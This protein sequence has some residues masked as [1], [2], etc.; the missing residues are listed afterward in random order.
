MKTDKD[1]L[2]FFIGTGLLIVA[3]LEVTILPYVLNMNFPTLF[4]P[5]DKHKTAVGY[6]YMLAFMSYFFSLGYFK[7][8][9][10]AI[11]IILIYYILFQYFVSL[12]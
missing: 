10:A 9:M 11:S 6:I 2:L 5:Q 3:I 12:I 7:K 4:V 1:R 8:Q